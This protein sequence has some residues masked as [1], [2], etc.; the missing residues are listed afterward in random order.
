M[1]EIK[2]EKIESLGWKNCYRVSNGLIEFVATGDVG[3]RIISL[4]FVGQK[5]LFH[6][7]GEMA[8]QVG[9]AKWCIYGGH[10]LWHSP[11]DK[12]RTYELD[13]C[14]IEVEQLPNGLFLRQNVEP[15]AGIQKTVEITIDPSRPRV[16]LVHRLKNNNLWPVELA[17]WALSVM[18]Q[19]G[20]GI[21]PLPRRFHPDYLLP[22]R[23]LTLWPYTDM[24]DSRY[25][26]GK[27]FVLL[28]HSEGGNPTKVGI[29]TDEEWCA[30]YL[31]PCLLV[32]RFAFAREARYPDFDCSVEVYTNTDMLELETLSPLR[33]IQPGMDLVHEEWWELHNGID[34]AFSEEEIRSKV[35][36]L[37]G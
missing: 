23:S 26:W 17:A 20:F 16:R 15:R 21:V 24:R 31:K 1:S 19:G 11:E 29:Y 36:P 22:N 28:R 18:E 30:Y 37:I 5:N 8:G 32:K 27:D 6:V 13:N 9:D 7:Y 25:L 34:L 14:P 10:R 33:T 4:A 2:T 3:P 35:V 12:A